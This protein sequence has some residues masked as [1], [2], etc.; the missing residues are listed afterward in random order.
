MYLKKSLQ[1]VVLCILVLTSA[2]AIANK[3]NV[4]YTNN[5]SNISNIGSNTSFST[6]NFTDKAVYVLDHSNDPSE[7]NWITMGSPS[8][9]RG[10]QLP[11]SI[12]ITYSGPRFETYRGI[13]WNLSSSSNGNFMMSYPSTSSYTTFP[14][15]LPGEN[16]SMSFFG[17]S[18]LEGNVSI[19][20][21]NVTSKSV[22]ETLKSLRTGN[23]TGLES[24]FHKNIAGNYGNYSAVLGENGDLSNYELGSFDPG[25]YCIVMAQKNVDG[26]LKLLS[27]TA[28]LVAEYELK[29]SAPASIK[30]GK[31]LDVN[32][33]LKGAPKDVNYTYG[34]LL[35]NE[36]V[37]KANIDIISNGTINSTSILVN[38]V[39]LTDK[40]NI[41]SSN[42]KSKLTKSELQKEI[43]T[44]IGEGNGSIAVGEQGQDKLSLTTFDL[45]Q[46]LYY[47]F[48]G[49]YDPKGK[50]AGLSQL[51]IEIAPRNAQVHPVANFTKSVTSSN[52]PLSVRFTDTSE[53]AVTWLWNFGDGASSTEQ[54]PIHTYSAE[55]N[56]NVILTVSNE[57]GT[58]SKLA[59]LTVSGKP[60]PVLPVANFSSNITGGYA[61]L[62][63]QFT[64][65]SKNANGWLWN[66]GDGNTSVLQNP[67]HTY[68][69]SGTYPVNLTVSNDNGTSLKS[70]PISVL[71]NPLESLSNVVIEESSQ[72][73]VLSKIPSSFHF[74]NGYTPIM[75][76]NF[77]TGQ[78]LGDTLVTVVLL[79]GKSS[80]TYGAPSGILYQ[81][82]DILINNATSAA[83]E[84]FYNASISF[85]VNKTWVQNNNLNLSSIVLNRYH[86]GMWNALPTV[87]TGQDANYL[88]FTAVTPGFS[89]FA[90]SGT[91]IVPESDVNS[92]VNHASYSVFKSV[93]APD[94][95]GDCIV[96]SLGDQIPYRIVVN[97]DGNVD[98][99]GV[100]VSDP[101][102]SLT[103]PSGDNNDP[104][105]LNQGET[106][107]YNGIYTLTPDDINNENDYID[108][109]ATVSCDQLPEKT[110]TVGQPID[111]K[112]D[113]SIQKSLLGID[114][115]G[116]FTVNEPGDIINYQIAVKNNGNV[117]LHNVKVT[118]S[119]IDDLSGPT[120][121]STDPGVLNSG[122]TWIYKG[123]Y[124]V[125]QEEITNKGEDGS[126]FIKNTATVTCDEHTSKSSTIEVPV[127][128]K[129]FKGNDSDPKNSSAK[130][131]PIAD[132]NASPTNGYAPLSVQFTDNST[133][134]PTSWR[135][136]FNNDGIIDSSEKNPV[137]VYATP[138][139][140]I[141]NL[142]V[143]NENG[144]TSKTA[145]ITIIEESSS[146]GSSGSSGGS[147]SSS[148]SFSSPESAG[149]VLSKESAKQFVSNGK[150]VR[151][152]LTKGLTSIMYVEFK[153]KK[154]VGDT[155][156]TI[157]ELKGKSILTPI[158]PS[159]EV[160]KY[161]NIWV[162]KNG[163][164]N[165]SNI[166]NATIGFKVRK[167][168]INGS[169]IK[170]NSLVLQH[171][172]D[173]KWEPL[174]T[175][176]VNE[177]QEYIYYKAKTPSFSPFAISGEKLII[178]DN[179]EKG[180]VSSE[181]VPNN[182]KAP[183]NRTGSV[184]QENKSG[185]I[186]KIT[187]FFIGLLVILLAGAIILKKK[188]PQQ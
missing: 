73:T 101:M 12:T 67:L 81:Y 22:S 168:W 19:C 104:G 24:V 92:T 43:Q 125:T 143:S 149:N 17:T 15:Y 95:S 27:A 75:V 90:I 16:V 151:F 47:L 182:E 96:N 93:V 154:S 79:K 114:E 3:N 28:F 140:S 148:G 153:A 174:P 159:G 7:G 46:G 111:K 145:N 115:A 116:D 13:S 133:G 70:T 34:A 30:E 166:E 44:L 89:P 59:I 164:A 102:I 187:S 78:T 136:D 179:G 123:N 120:G 39:N 9:A 117:N 186:L 103:G 181:T 18:A 109:T 76:I 41:N 172:S 33:N 40:F 129:K 178:E 10:I 175:E 54:N 170:A 55:G 135:W 157:E 50:I 134:S 176:K 107:V 38:G 128:P 29:A 23:L 36:Q 69:T 82:L 124:A 64:D 147:G 52:A 2:T 112:T 126:G 35:V 98:L 91:A 71:Q 146:G 163:F 141:V 169:K 161:I 26:S 185:G 99:T 32:L 80:L 105:V 51:I 100:S 97:N 118:D 5:I 142:T 106:W 122:E 66:F 158:E 121:D 127:I 130:V 138:G 108:N 131:L 144:T 77:S 184:P 8:E 11:K 85:K 6:F 180:Q 37:Y 167:D 63:V 84:D 60:V 20:V 56:Y 21:F 42:Y 62:S 162:G 53:N 86:N 183:T 139:T 160:Y 165:S 177:D 1:I 61:P 14:V 49:A 132:F 156:T 188:G 48:V 4:G 45:P 31:N 72:A 83:S 94:E 58:N 119:L 87:L 137:F 152:E 155:T 173:K 25:Q 57:K 74:S 68:F 113:L 110:S 65:L 150:L 171:F 88:Y